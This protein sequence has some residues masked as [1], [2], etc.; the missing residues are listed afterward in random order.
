MGGTEKAEIWT[1]I[2]TDLPG[3]GDLPEA[4]WNWEDVW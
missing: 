4:F 3:F 2:D 1:V